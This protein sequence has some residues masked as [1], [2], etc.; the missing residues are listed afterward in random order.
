[1]SQRSN[2]RRH[3]DLTSIP[4]SAKDLFISQ[5]PV[6]PLQRMRYR[7]P[8]SHGDPS[9]EMEARHLHAERA[10]D[11]LWETVRVVQIA[12]TMRA[13]K[14]E[15]LM[16]SVSQMISVWFALEHIVFRVDAC[17]FSRLDTEASQ[18]TRFSH[19]FTERHSKNE[20][21]YIHSSGCR[22]ARLSVGRSLGAAG[23]PASRPARAFP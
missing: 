2:S 5:P 23:R 19:R 22:A 4:F 17:C 21:W 8:I 15:S 6:C 10:R 1:M 3:A 9:M 16:S 13:S 20:W 18:P 7:T 12:F 14:F 11:K